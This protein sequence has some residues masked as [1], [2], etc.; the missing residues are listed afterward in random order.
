MY[1]FNTHS[2]D[3]INVSYCVL[4]YHAIDQVAKH[5]KLTPTAK[6]AF[7]ILLTYASYKR[8]EAFDVTTAWISEHLN[9]DRKTVATALKQLKEFGFASEQGI[10][11]PMVNDSFKARNDEQPS[12][13]QTKST[14]NQRRQAR[15]TAALA[16]DEARNTQKQYGHVSSTPTVE[17]IAIAVNEVEKEIVQDTQPAPAQIDAN[18]DA[19]SLSRQYRKLLTEKFKAFMS[20]GFLKKDAK[21]RAQNAA[22]IECGKIAHLENSD[23]QSWGKIPDTEGKIT[24]EMGKNYPSHIT[25]LNTNKKQNKPI[26]V[27]TEE[28]TKAEQQTRSGDVGVFSFSANGG[29]VPTAKNASVSQTA[30]AL[31]GGKLRYVNRYIESSLQRMRMGAKEIETYSTDINFSLKNGAFAE[32]FS[33]CPMKAVRACLKIVEAGKWNLQAGIY[34]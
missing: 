10:I 20:V 19:K 25:N 34:A 9:A 14:I 11:V 5:D 3:G 33:Q 30:K 4:P 12:V 27:N 29:N 8:S 13:S 18:A 21:R 23:T 32:T 15:T 24:H 17:S 26:Q 6:N 2:I 28:L 1:D 16:L 22:K 31:H 7:F